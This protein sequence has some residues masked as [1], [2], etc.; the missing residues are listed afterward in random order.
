MNSNLA[1]SMI[2]QDLPRKTWRE[3][4]PGSG[5]GLELGWT[6]GD[7]IQKKKMRLQK[8]ENEADRWYP[9][10]LTH[11]WHSYLPWWGGLFFLLAFSLAELFEKAV[12]RERERERLELV[13]GLAGER[14]IYIY[15]FIYLFIHISFDLCM[16]VYVY[17]HMYIYVC[18]YIYIYPC[19]YVYMY[20]NITF[21]CMYVYMCIC[22][23][24]YICMYV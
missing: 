7:F 1:S 14:S 4:S 12:E 15:L 22:R 23:A 2:P 5:V 9:W 13:L 24:S 10:L 6:L 20:I 11:C 18:M 16:R 21:I 3:K 19:V 8:L 17:M